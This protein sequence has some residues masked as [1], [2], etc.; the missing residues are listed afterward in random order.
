MGTSELPLHL[1]SS[2]G[3]S[4]CRCHGT[5]TSW[6]VC[7]RGCSCPLER[8]HG[9]PVKSPDEVTTHTPSEL[10]CTYPA[11]PNL[12]S[13]PPQEETIGS[14]TGPGCTWG[15]VTPHSP[16]L[17]AVQGEEEGDPC[18][19]LQLCQCI[20]SL[21]PMQVRPSLVLLSNAAH[22]FLQDGV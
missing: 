13:A 22:P 15:A 19:C 2:P 20:S 17:G 21:G 10:L 11:W 14:P 6:R 7:H 4:H 8:S 18:F 12:S 1:F 16:L 5:C 9:L 3:S